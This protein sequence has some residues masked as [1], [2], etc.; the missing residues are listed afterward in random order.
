MGD[1]NYLLHLI[2]RTGCLVHVKVGPW[3]SGYSGCITIADNSAGQLGSKIR[4]GS[5]GL[6]VPIF[7][8]R[9]G[10]CHGEQGWLALFASYDAEPSEEDYQQFW[11]SADGGFDKHGKETTYR[12]V[13]EKGSR[14]G[15]TVH[16]YWTLYD[17]ADTFAKPK[18]AV[19]YPDI[20][21]NGSDDYRFCILRS[22][23]VSKT[24]VIPVRDGATD[25]SFQLVLRNADVAIHVTAPNG[26]QFVSELHSDGVW[27]T[28][29]SDRSLGLESFHIENP[30]AGNWEAKVISRDGEEW[31]LVGSTNQD[32]ASS[33]ARNAFS[34]AP[35]SVERDFYA[36]FG[37]VRPKE[38][39]PA[40][41]CYFCQAQAIVIVGLAAATFYFGA[42]PVTATSAV[43]LYAERLLGSRVASLVESINKLCAAWQAGT[44]TFNLARLFCEYEGMCSKQNEGTQSLG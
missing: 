4:L 30:G 8:W 19:S 17:A 18:F 43:V 29:A 42:G 15:D 16:L 31:S 28:P 11:F 10:S 7:F 12:N 44:N 21:V 25:L 32:K 2:N 37:P 40:E 23:D 34:Q 39:L 35:P 24:C 36:S 3:A 6:P 9:S 27:A 20:E 33:A 13:L 41:I 22:T 38:K 26:T 1:A 5:S 14:V